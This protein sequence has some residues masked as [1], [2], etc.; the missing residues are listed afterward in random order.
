MSRCYCMNWGKE[1]V[2][3]VTEV[4]CSL[5]PFSHWNHLFFFFISL[6]V[7]RVRKRARKDDVFELFC[8][9]RKRWERGVAYEPSSTLKVTVE[10]TPR[11]EPSF[12]YDRHM[13]SPL[14]LSATSQHLPFIRR[15]EATMSSHQ[16][17][18]RKPN[19]SQFLHGELGEKV[20]DCLCGRLF[21]FTFMSIPCLGSLSRCVKWSSIGATTAWSHPGFA[22][23]CAS[24]SVR[25]WSGGSADTGM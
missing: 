24:V 14:K 21:L 22:A 4:I 9:E 18:C 8:N 11:G 23:S 13:E 17:N 12:L 6:G 3:C 20:C 25:F 16:M 7:L 1:Y 5:S 19:Y 2:P 10:E 15:S